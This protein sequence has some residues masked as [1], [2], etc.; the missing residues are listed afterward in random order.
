MK[1]EIKPISETKI[2]DIQVTLTVSQDELYLLRRAL[3]DLKNNGY[4]HDHLYLLTDFNKIIEE[5]KKMLEQK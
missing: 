2:I 3:S 4:L 5:T 1:T